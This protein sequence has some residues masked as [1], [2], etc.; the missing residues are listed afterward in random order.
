M[1]RPGEAWS[2]ADR[3]WSTWLANKRR[4]T[5]QS[6]AYYIHP[7]SLGNKKNNREK[8]NKKQTLRTECTMAPCAD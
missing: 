4:L 1:S 2:I 6:R 5:R 3:F 7:D 8:K